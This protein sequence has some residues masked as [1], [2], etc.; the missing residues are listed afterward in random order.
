MGTEDNDSCWRKRRYAT[1]EEAEA[2]APP[3]KRSYLCFR[4][5]WW[6]NGSF[7]SRAKT[8]SIGRSGVPSQ[9]AWAAVAAGR[10]R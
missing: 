1:R 7:R 6:H 2:H 5:Q 3:R 4:C 9:E 8:V 10:K